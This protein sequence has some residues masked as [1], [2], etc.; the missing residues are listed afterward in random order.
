MID[1]IVEMA[2]AAS[3][4]V[5]INRA[6]KRHRWVRIFQAVIWLAFLIALVALIYVTVKYS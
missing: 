6:A 3:A 4:D 1:D 2:I 5:A